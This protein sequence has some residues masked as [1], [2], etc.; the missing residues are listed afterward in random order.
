[1]TSQELTQFLEAI[2]HYDVLMPTKRKRFMILSL[3]GFLGILAALR[4]GARRRS[5]TRA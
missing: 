3:V 4:R 5:Y 1:M 2:E